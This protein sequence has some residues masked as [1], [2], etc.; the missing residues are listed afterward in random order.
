MQ[1][2]L[3]RPVRLTPGDTIRVELPYSD[4]CLHWG[5]AGRVHD[6]EL[7]RDSKGLGA[8]R[9]LDGEGCPFGPPITAGEAGIYMDSRG[10]YTYPA[11]A[12]QVVR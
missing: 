1:P 2:I 10:F 3:D 7:T 8:V 9:V 6:V 5:I 12:K 11:P 4:A